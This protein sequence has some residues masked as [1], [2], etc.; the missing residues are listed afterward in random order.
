M[1][2]NE[3]IRDISKEDIINKDKQIHEEM[4]KEIFD[5]TYNH[6]NK[7]NNL[8][9]RINILKAIMDI[10]QSSSM[11]IPDGKDQNVYYGAQSSLETEID[12]TSV[13]KTPQ[14]AID[15]YLENTENIYPP[16]IYTITYPLYRALSKL[17][18]DKIIKK[19]Y[20]TS[21]IITDK[22]NFMSDLSP[23]ISGLVDLVQRV[24]PYPSFQLIISIVKYFQNNLNK[25]F[26]N[27]NM[28]VDIHVGNTLFGNIS[29]ENNEIVESVNQKEFDTKCFDYFYCKNMTLT[30]TTESDFTKQVFD[31]ISQNW[32]NGNIMNI[33]FTIYNKNN[34]SYN[35]IN[36]QMLFAHT[37]TPPKISISFLP[38]QL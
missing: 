3:E 24:Y 11:P 9:D 34:N 10:I 29:I 38:N 12:I 26:E 15:K 18:N 36:L 28:S 25:Y 22:Y 32:L 2:K 6:K 21:I 13:G 37:D 31:D 30:T 35:F 4:A 33:L 14:E 20:P 17:N 1:N 23:A 27:L 8:S 7:Q 5:K 16:K 19:M